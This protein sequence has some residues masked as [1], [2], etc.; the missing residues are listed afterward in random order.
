M[1]EAL[2]QGRRGR[3]WAGR[4]AGNGHGMGKETTGWD[5]AGLLVMRGVVL[6][7]HDERALR[8][9]A[10]AVHAAALTL[11]PYSP[12]ATRGTPLPLCVKHKQAHW[13]AEPRVWRRLAGDGDP[14]LGVQ[15]LHGAAARILG[16]LQGAHRACFD[17]QSASRQCTTLMECTGHDASGSSGALQQFW[18]GGLP[19][20]GP[21]EV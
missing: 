19:A 10:P 17:Q 5:L 3:G 7:G 15:P 6:S 9:A 13:Y 18:L 14:A 1:C 2:V 8:S 20:T 11:L 4:G 12:V 21:G 16:I